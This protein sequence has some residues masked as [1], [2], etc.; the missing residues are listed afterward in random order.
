[1]ILTCCRVPGHDRSVPVCGSDDPFRALPPRHGTSS[2]TGLRQP[3]KFNLPQTLHTGPHCP[4]SPTCQPISAAAHPDSTTPR[5]PCPARPHP[6]NRI[7]AFLLTT[8]RRLRSLR[9]TPPLPTSRIITCHLGPPDV[10]GLVGSTRSDPC[11][12]DRPSHRFP[13]HVDSSVLIQPLPPVPDDPAQCHS[14]QSSSTHLDRYIY[15]YY[16]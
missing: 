1:M 16:L 5:C 4:T 9:I 3:R 13:A 8:P 7:D 10:S 2:P 11:L 6:T 14:F 12:L 15:G